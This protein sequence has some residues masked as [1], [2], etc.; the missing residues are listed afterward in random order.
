[1][2]KTDDS[3]EYQFTSFVP[4]NFSSPVLTTFALRLDLTI[5][6]AS[7]TMRLTI[8]G[9]LEVVLQGK[10]DFGK[11]GCGGPC[12]PGLGHRYHF[13]VYA[14]DE[15]SDLAGSVS[16]KEILGAMQGHILARG[17]LTGI[18]W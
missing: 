9:W 4:F 3:G 2:L 7:A 11:I 13:I 8:A 6:Q 10:N 16:R 15:P 17:Q 12:P 5:M 18:Y 1:M 14:L